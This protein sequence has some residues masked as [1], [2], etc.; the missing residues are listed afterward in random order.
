MSNYVAATFKSPENPCPIAGFFVVTQGDISWLMIYRTGPSIVRLSP[1]SSDTSGPNPPRIYREKPFILHPGHAACIASR[2][3]LRPRAAEYSQARLGATVAMLALGSASAF[4]WSQHGTATRRVAPTTARVTAR[5]AAVV[6]RMRA[7]SPALTAASQQHGHGDAQCTG[8][9]LEFGHGDRALRQFGSACR[10]HQLRRRHLLAHRHTDRAG[11]QDGHH[12]RRRD[13][14]RA[15][16]VFVVGIDHGLKRQHG[17]SFG[18]DELR[19]LPCSRS[20][21]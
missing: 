3:R 20:G 5:A 10:R 13:E 11:R 1:R 15:W 18:I 12:L 16:P 17:R 7:A 4:A 9:V 21:T 6:V 14:N 8:R 2:P 19:G